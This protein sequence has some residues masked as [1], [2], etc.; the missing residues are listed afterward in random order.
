MSEEHF[1]LDSIMTVVVTDNDIVNVIVH[2]DAIAEYIEDT[3]GDF[4]RDYPALIA[5]AITCGHYTLTGSKRGQ[6]EVK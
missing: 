4:S 1:F 3:Y 6:S 5:K 2:L